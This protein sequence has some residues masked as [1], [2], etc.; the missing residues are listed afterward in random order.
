MEKTTLPT[1]TIK[2]TLFP[3]TIKSIIRTTPMTVV[4]SLTVGIALY[5]TIAMSHV[6]LGAIL[7]TI[8]HSTP[9]MLMLV[10][11]AL[12]FILQNVQFGHKAHTHETHIRP[13]LSDAAVTRQDKS[14]NKNYLL[15]KNGQLLLLCSTIST[16]S[17]YVGCMI[18]AMKLPIYFMIIPVIAIII[19]IAM[20]FMSNHTTD[21]TTITLDSNSQSLAQIIS[22]IN[23][24]NKFK[25]L[26]TLELDLSNMNLET[27][28]TL[29]SKL[30]GLQYINHLNITVNLNNNEDT[31]NIAKQLTDKLGQLKNIQML[32]L[33]LSNT[34]F[35]DQGLTNLAANL[36]K[37]QNLHELCLDLSHNTY[38]GTGLTN[39][40]MSLGGLQNLSK[41]DLSLSNT[42]FN[43]P[44]DLA[45]SLTSLKQLKNLNKL[46]LNLSNNKYHH[47]ELTNL[48]TGLA[49]LQK[50][51][52]LD[53]SLSNT[54]FNDQG[55]KNLTMSLGGLQNLNRL[56]L[57]LNNTTL[58]D[59][60][61]DELTKNL[62]N[63]NHMSTLHLSLESA[64]INNLKNFF[65]QFANNF[66]NH[67]HTLTLN[68]D[69]ADAL[70]FDKADEINENMVMPLMDKLT[71]LNTVMKLKITLSNKDLQSKFNDI[72]RDQLGNIRTTKDGYVKHLIKEKRWID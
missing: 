54:T 1:D 28:K 4:N 18:L 41:L 21:I 62:K 26:R 69:K 32:N 36:G 50:L 49:E 3:K 45:A 67:L 11:S 60:V 66:N 23:H 59:Q 13:I 10:C 20:T 53:I 17:C 63:M 47:K 27:C 33:S 35:T 46:Y 72:F 52:R 58:S 40:T 61:I 29:T 19:S 5:L 70:N 2:S 7:L 30:Q 12:I 22:K 25:N 16:I 71:T 14:L 42:Q 9:I 34:R 64:R 8:S 48:A 55:L 39:L 65:T 38:K 68:F 31:D 37:L 6:T 57:H 15:H 51:D 43:Q 56:E 24:L 44:T